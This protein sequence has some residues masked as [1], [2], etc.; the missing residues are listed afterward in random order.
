M[1]K[2]IINFFKRNGKSPSTAILKT[3]AVS[4]AHMTHDTYSGF[5]APLLPSLIE[6]LSL[7]KA[8]AGFFSLVYQGVSI[9]QPFIGH[10][11]DRTNLR[12]Y[13]LLAPALTGIFLSLLGPAP[14]FS[15]ALFYCLI[16]GISSATL[17]STLPALVSSFS[18]KNVGKRMSIWMIGGELG[19]MLGPVIITAVLTSFSVY[20]TPWLMIGGILASIFLS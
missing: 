8:E 10:M 13:A 6:R 5:I 18:D 11:G 19:V 16:A 7:T 4:F 1:Q 20:Q 15:T 2:S 9:L 3:I 17:H 14:S 12:K